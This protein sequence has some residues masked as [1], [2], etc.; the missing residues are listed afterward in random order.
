MWGRGKVATTRKFFAALGSGD[1]AA[2]A[3]L[4]HPEIRYVDARGNAVEG[5]EA[6]TELLRRLFAR[7]GGVRIAIDSIVDRG[8]YALARGRTKAGDE[9]IAGE[10]LWC[11]KTEGDRVV[12]VEAHRPDG[13]PTARLLMPEYLERQ[14]ARAPAPR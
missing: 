7:G 4:F 1:A 3:A 6:C 9:Q 12:E 2:C 14:R 8:D 11:V 13:L 10:V 5:I